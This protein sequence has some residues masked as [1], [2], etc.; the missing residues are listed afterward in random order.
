M[1]PLISN[2]SSSIVKYIYIGFVEPLMR[3]HGLVYVCVHDFIAFQ[4]VMLC[5][6][7]GV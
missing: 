6:C 5:T 2:H 7:L 1:G 3:R 4:Y